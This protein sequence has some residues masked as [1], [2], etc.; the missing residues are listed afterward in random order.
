[1]FLFLHAPDECHLEVLDNKCGY[2]I[3]QTVECSAKMGAAIH[4]AYSFSIHAKLNHLHFFIELFH[5]DFSKLV[6]TNY[7]YLYCG[8]LSS[9]ENIEICSDMPRQY[10][11][12]PT[13]CCYCCCCYSTVKPGRPGPPTLGFKVVT[14]KSITEVAYFT[15]LSFCSAL[16]ILHIFPSLALGYCSSGGGEGDFI[17]Y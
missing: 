12:N 11:L 4:Y 10:S 9:N 16:C 1:M 15:L 17:S 13:I 6:R 5:N 8:Y 3:T 14:V 7:T 2:G